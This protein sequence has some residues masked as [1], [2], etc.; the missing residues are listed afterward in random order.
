MTR[1]TRPACDAHSAISNAGASSGP[2]GRPSS[3]LARRCSCARTLSRGLLT[4]RIRLQHWPPPLVGHNAHYAPVRFAFLQPRAQPPLARRA[5]R[6]HDLDAAAPRRFERH[7]TWQA[8][9]A[10]HASCRL[11]HPIDRSGMHRVDFAAGVQ[12]TT[13]RDRPAARARRVDREHHALWRGDAGASTLRDA[14]THCRSPRSGLTRRDVP[15]SNV[16]GGSGAARRR[17]V[18]PEPRRRSRRRSALLRTRAAR[19]R[20]LWLCG[21]TT[22]LTVC[23]NVARVSTAHDC[24]RLRRHHDASCTCVARSFSAARASACNSPPTKTNPLRALTARQTA[25]LVV[26][27]NRPATASQRT[28]SEAGA[29]N[30]ANSDAGNPPGLDQ[31]DVARRAHAGPRAVIPIELGTTRSS[32]KWYQ[33]VPPA[34]KSRGWGTT[35]MVVPGTTGEPPG[36]TERRALMTRLLHGR[37]SADSDP[38]DIPAGLLRA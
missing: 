14:R 5:E 2:A 3:S 26:T 4:K 31:R 19:G 36:T 24:A 28:T 37:F 18:M 6:R 29:G 23:K 22:R 16:S 15:A 35:W 17:R 10:R 13:N 30:H 11:H 27:S 21:L 9:R 38:S 34:L 8:H 12:L 20:L 33:V 7:H 1:P 25:W 32:R